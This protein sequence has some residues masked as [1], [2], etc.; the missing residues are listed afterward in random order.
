MLIK[1]FPSHIINSVKINLEFCSRKCRARY[2]TAKRI[3]FIK[4]LSA[5][6][7]DVHRFLYRLINK[8]RYLAVL[9][10]ESLLSNIWGNFLDI[11][12]RQCHQSIENSL[13]VCRAWDIKLTSQ[14]KIKK[15]QNVY[16][17]I[18][19]IRF[20]VNLKHGN[21]QFSNDKMVLKFMSDNL[22]HAPEMLF[23]NI[24]LNLLHSPNFLQFLLNLRISVTTN[25]ITILKIN[26]S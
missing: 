7:R 23:R 13:T 22:N 25:L 19:P 9:L 16:S 11:Q 26:G 1:I 15:V 18:K 24:A 2:N 6:I 14:T 10:K 3:F 5:Q 12:M 17:R 8:S 20:F 4:M 21:S